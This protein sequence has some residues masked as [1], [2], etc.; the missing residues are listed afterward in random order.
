MWNSDHDHV[1]DVILDLTKPDIED[2]RN[3]ACQIEDAIIVMF[4]FCMLRS[5]VSS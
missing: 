2:Q 4:F 5:S 3:Q 1:I